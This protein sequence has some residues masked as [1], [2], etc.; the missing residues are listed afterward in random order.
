LIPIASPLTYY[1]KGQLATVLHGLPVVCNVID[2]TVFNPLPGQTCEA[3][4][5]EWV[6]QVGGYL[7]NPTATSL[8]GYC[9]FSN[10]DDYLAT[11]DAPYNFRWQSFGIFLG[12]T[13]FNASMTFFLYWY[14]R[15]RGYELGVGWL[16]SK[17][18][19]LFKKR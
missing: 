4:A 12:F 15:V 7:T 11:L 19:D 5:G 17:I 3:Y 1:V 10:G 8:C 16:V 18:T 13:I 6:S 14:F 2:T 9:Q